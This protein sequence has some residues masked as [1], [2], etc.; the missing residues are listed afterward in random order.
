VVWGIGHLGAMAWTMADPQRSWVPWAV[1]MPACAAVVGIGSW[2]RHRQERVETTTGR[3]LQAIWTAFGGAAWL[4]WVPML[5]GGDERDLAACFG[6]FFLTIGCAN[7]ACGSLLRWPIQKAV[8]ISWWIAWAI[9]M[10]HP[11]ITAIAWTFAAMA[12]IGE[13][14]FGLYLMACEKRDRQDG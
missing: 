14:M 7:Y 2:R 4:L 8:A 3:A 9:V 11:T 1:L 5:H 10:Y 12:L 6:A 13:L